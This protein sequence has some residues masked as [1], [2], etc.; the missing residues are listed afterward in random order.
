MKSTVDQIINNLVKNDIV[1]AF[2]DAMS[3]QDTNF[4]ILYQNK[5]AINIIGNHVGKICYEAFE[6]RNRICEECPLELSMKD[7]KVRTAV[8]RNPA[9]KNLV[10]EITSSPL[11]D[12]SGR[13]IAGIE[14]VRDVTKRK[15]L[16]EER[17][18][19]MRE[20]NYGIEK[21]KNLNGI[22][23]MCCT[24]NKVHE[25]S[26][27]WT[28]IDVFIKR[29]SAAKLSHGFCPECAAKIYPQEK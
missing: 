9:K 27:N 20:V 2:G 4:R 16:K 12:A 23:H 1:K 3:I 24:C 15:K 6:Q 11:K 18:R 25:E 19:S 13:I 28:H 14:I 8:R 21:I 22:L 17:A 5:E 26:G 29:H 7:G 10:V